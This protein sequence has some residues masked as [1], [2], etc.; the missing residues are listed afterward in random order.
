MSDFSRTPSAEGRVAPF[1]WSA[2]DEEPELVVAAIRQLERRPG[3]HDED[4]AALEL[5]ALGIVTFPMW[6]VSVPSR[7]TNTS[8]CTGSM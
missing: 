3:L 7:T 8:S 6:I 2:V 4:A 5:V 1:G